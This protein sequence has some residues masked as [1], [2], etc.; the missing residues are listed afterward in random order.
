MSIYA[1]AVGTTRFRFQALLQFSGR[2][3]YKNQ[4][5]RSKFEQKVDEHATQLVINTIISVIFVTFSFSLSLIGTMYVLIF[6][7]TYAIPTGHVMPFVDAGTL[8]GYIINMIMQMFVAVCALIAVLSL[9]MASC[10]IN[11][12]YAVMADL[13]CYA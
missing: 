6:H 11:N 12:T 13:V 5:A 8:R 2:F 9:E 10:I 7:G 1:I 3:I 4:I